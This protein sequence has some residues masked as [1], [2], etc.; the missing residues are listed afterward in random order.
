MSDTELLPKSEPVRRL[1]VFIGSGLRRAWTVEQKARIVAESYES[2]ATVSA[3]A[4]RHGV[5]PQ[6][7]FAWRR[8]A[9]RRA[10][11]SGGESGLTFAPVVVAP[12]QKGARV[13]WPSTGTIGSG[14]STI[15][16]VI[17]ATTVRVPAGADAMTLQAVLRAVKAM[18]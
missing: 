5:T 14:T 17:G 7:L 11:E 13:S 3:V 4:R 10:V 16:V 18:S 1:E 8:L 6:Q 12:V 2:G 15:E 9:R